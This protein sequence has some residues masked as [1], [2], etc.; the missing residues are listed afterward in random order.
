MVIRGVLAC[1]HASKAAFVVD[2][3]NLCTHNR[4]IKHSYRRA[5]FRRCVYLDN[6]VNSA[7]EIRAVVVDDYPS[8]VEKGGVNILFVFRI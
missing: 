3:R 4:D 8:V 7:S 6:H 1:T 2:V 5:R